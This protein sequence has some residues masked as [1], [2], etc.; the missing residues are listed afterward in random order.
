MPIA[1][2]IPGDDGFSQRTAKTRSA[3]KW[4]S[5]KHHARWNQRAENIFSTTA[6]TLWALAGDIVH[7]RS[8]ETCLRP[9]DRTMTSS[10]VSTT[11]SMA[12]NTSRAAEYKASI[13]AT[14]ERFSLS[15][16]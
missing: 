10:A 15:F 5:W 4:Y 7:S 11:S 2:K 12:T 13:E 8:S 16:I 14:A 3:L 6:K 1:D 9:S